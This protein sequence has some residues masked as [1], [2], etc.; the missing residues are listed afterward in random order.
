MEV[1]LVAFLTKGEGLGT[2]G[3]DGCK[4]IGWF[5][6]KGVLHRG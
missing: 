2:T 4:Y 6:G 1:V 5:V 3:L